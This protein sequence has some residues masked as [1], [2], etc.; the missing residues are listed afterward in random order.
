MILLLDDRGLVVKL[1]TTVSICSDD[2]T[3]KETDTRKRIERARQFVTG[4]SE[5]SAVDDRAGEIASVVLSRRTHLPKLRPIATDVSAAH[6]QGFHGALAD[7]AT[8]VRLIT[9][10]V[11]SVGKHNVYMALH[12]KTLIV[13]A[14]TIDGRALRNDVLADIAQGAHD[15]CRSFVGC[16][17]DDVTVALRVRDAIVAGVRA[18]GVIVLDAVPWATAVF[19]CLDEL[20]YKKVCAGIRADRFPRVSAAL[21]GSLSA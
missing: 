4:V 2:V 12:N 3:D 7:D 5:A 10:A 13:Q 21:R 17:P 8:T 6:L 15:D 14:V 1:L 16:A 19:T 18:S 11:Y 9:S 20:Q